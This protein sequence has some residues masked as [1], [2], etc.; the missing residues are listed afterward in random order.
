MSAGASLR[1]GT[2]IRFIPVSIVIGFTSGIAVIIATSQVA[3]F[4]GLDAGK[5]PADFLGK[6]QA[7]VA[8]LPTLQ[9]PTLAIGGGTLLAIVLLRR[10]APQWPAYLLALLAAT[11]AVAL[12]LSILPNAGHAY[13]QEEQAACQPD[14][15]RLCS[16]E[17]PDVDRV[18]A[19]MVAKKS[20]L[21]PQCRAHFRGPEPRR[22][23]AGGRVGR[24][25]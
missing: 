8:A 24:S 4:L 20:Q 13:T 16:S 11:L 3:D 12:T 5:V 10:F 2:L 9:L 25:P 19:C 21:S 14:A 22:E 23:A 6:W 18:T 15:F 1:M 17:I 7:Y